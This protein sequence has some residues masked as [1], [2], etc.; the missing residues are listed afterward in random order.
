MFDWV[1][2]GLNEW[3][4]WFFTF[5]LSLKKEKSFYVI[6]KIQHNKLDLFID[7]TWMKECVALRWFYI[8]K[9]NKVY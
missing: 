7:H 6:W 1:H 5:S 8:L 3:S 9:V 2:T 4:K